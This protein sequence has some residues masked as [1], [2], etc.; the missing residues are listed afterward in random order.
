M[1][2][3]D[4]TYVN[5]EQYLRA[6]QFWIDT[7]E[8]QTRQLGFRQYLYPFYVFDDEINFNDDK[9]RDTLSHLTSELLDTQKDIPADS[10]EEFVL[11]NTGT[12]FDIWLAK[13]CDL[14]FIQTRLHEQYDD[15]WIGFKCKDQLDFDQKSWIASIQLGKS[16]LYFFKKVDE[17]TIETI[18]D[19]YVFGTT[20]VFKQ[21]SIAKRL[22]S[23]L[24]SYGNSSDMKITFEYRNVY[25]TLKGDGITLS[26]GEPV[27]FGY[28][29]DL[30]NWE[31]PKLHYCFDT[32]EVKDVDPEAIVFSDEDEFFMM[33][34][35]KDWS[36]DKLNRYIF[37]LPNYINEL[38]KTYATD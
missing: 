28:H 19:L 38:I 31:L 35:Y 4:K 6:R 18:D 23:G 33:T 15:N 17:D 22:I 13:Y 2:S 9:S 14:D 10:D 7:S 34:D 37:L 16:N 32:A 8:Q 29:D 36:K 24:P 30:N 21:Y 5:K 11:W 3:I 1:A 20:N 27:I 12:E 25:L 26:N